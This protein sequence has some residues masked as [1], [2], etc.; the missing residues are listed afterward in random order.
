MT[1]E[2]RDSDFLPFGQF[3]LAWRFTD[4]RHL[5]LPTEELTRVRPLVPAK[6]RELH[7]RSASWVQ[8]DGL[9]LPPYGEQALL[10]TGPLV[11][12]AGGTHWLRQ[13]GVAA[14]TELLVSW[15][16]QTAVL[17]D[18]S[19]FADHWDAFC[20]PASDDLLAWPFSEEWL[21]LYFHEER[22]AFARRSGNP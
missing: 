3:T 19:L 2:L 16:R 17:T 7:E 9:F 10:D 1:V 11:D 21:L 4:A 13:L 8:V 5:V 20:Y 12:T 18:A 6:A 15:D 14:A 22:L